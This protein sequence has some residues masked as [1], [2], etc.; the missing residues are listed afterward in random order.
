MQNVPR[1]MKEEGH[2]V[3]KLNKNDDETYDLF[4]EKGEE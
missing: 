2:K 4:V 1:S 3:L